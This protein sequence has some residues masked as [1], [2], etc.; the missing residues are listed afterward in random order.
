VDR[1]PLGTVEGIY[2]AQAGREPVYA[3]QEAKAVAGRGLQGDR[4]F[5]QTGTFSGTPGTGRQLTMIDAAT[6]EALER[7]HGIHLAPGATR[8]NLVTRGVDLSQLL[9]KRF[10][11][12]EVLCQG[13]RAC[14]PCAHLES[15]TQPGLVNA[16]LDRGGLR[17]DILQGGTIRVGA[18]VSLA[19]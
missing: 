8:R 11:V 5:T 16:L 18:E 9:G 6:L 14:P 12:G 3:R 2:L 10:W 1:R 7:E 4:Y 19:D 13:M 17:V 15:L